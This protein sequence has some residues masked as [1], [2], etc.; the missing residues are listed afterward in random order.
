[1]HLLPADELVMSE[2]RTTTMLHVSPGL[3]SSNLTKPV[4]EPGQVTS[5]ITV[6]KV[7]I[8]VLNRLEC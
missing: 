6:A 7:G 5:D 3:R 8:T 2:F 1:M 4:A